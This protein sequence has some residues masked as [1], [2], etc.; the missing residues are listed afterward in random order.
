MFWIA[1]S[2]TAAFVASVGWVRSHRL[3]RIATE[4]DRVASRQNGELIAERQRMRFEAG[5][6]QALLPSERGTA[7]GRL[8]TRLIPH[9][10]DGLATLETATGELLATRGRGSFD[11][12]GKT[13]R[14]TAAGGVRLTTT[15]FGPTSVPDHLAQRFVAD[16]LADYEFAASEDAA[17]LA[18]VKL[19][20]QTLAL[21]QDRLP[22]VLRRTLTAIVAE[23]G[24]D[25][26]TLYL[27][28]AHDSHQQVATVTAADGDAESLAAREQA[29]LDRHSRR[30]G[31]GN[32]VDR[33]V[34]VWE[35]VAANSQLGVLVLTGSGPVT[36]SSPQRQLVDWTADHL[37]QLLKD[38]AGRI[39]LERDATNDRLTG[40]LNRRA[41]DERLLESIANSR[42]NDTTVSLILIDIDH[43]KSVNDLHGHLA[44]DLAIRR[45]GELMV[46][47]VGQQRETDTYHLARYGGEELAVLSPDLPPDGAARIAEAIRRKIEANPVEWRD[48]RIALTVSAGHA[49]VSGVSADGER[50]IDLADTALYQAK[51]GGRNRVC[52]SNTPRMLRTEPSRR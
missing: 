9:L 32:D 39:Q 27:Q 48:E 50:L 42:S 19:G 38:S 5:I 23:T 1:I 29:A 11:R 47:I 35:L 51:R 25:R 49:T 2:L 7:A 44:G 8:L 37:A 10:D 34:G 4:S 20:L 31:D 21:G 41:F 22:E 26:A 3:F 17:T 43:F 28:T 45:V 15:Q 14:I 12:T 13:Y 30:R 6:L 33:R 24:A 40:L 52:A 18:E 46:E 36:E 16:V